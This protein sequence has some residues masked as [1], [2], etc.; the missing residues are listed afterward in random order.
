MYGVGDRDDDEAG[1]KRRRTA[2][3]EEVMSETEGEQRPIGESPMEQ[4][5]RL[6]RK[7]RAIDHKLFEELSKELAEE[8]EDEQF[9]KATE[10]ADEDKEPNADKMGM[11]SL[12]KKEM[13]EER[14]VHDT[15]ALG[16]KSMESAPKLN[17]PQDFLQ[18]AVSLLAGATLPKF[19]N[20][21][22]RGQ[23]TK[24][25]KYDSWNGQG[26]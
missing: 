5:E 11:D 22:I 24:A 23:V 7:E 21:G 1:N 25:Q 20:K 19:A 10:A 14:E 3:A 26:G 9:L 12:G 15:A 6:L 4:V 8:E 17:S 16:N 13:E 2:E 18:G